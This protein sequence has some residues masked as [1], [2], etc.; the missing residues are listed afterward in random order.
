[1]KNVQRAFILKF[2]S[3]KA[4]KIYDVTNQL[5]LNIYVKHVHHQFGCDI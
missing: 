1:M 2:I 3:L 5:S 4:S